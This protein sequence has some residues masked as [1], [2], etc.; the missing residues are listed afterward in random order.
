MLSSLAVTG[1]VALSRSPSLLYLVYQQSDPVRSD[2]IIRCTTHVS[3]QEQDVP[4]S[5][6][7]SAAMIIRCHEK[8]DSQSLPVPLS[9]E[10][11]STVRYQWRRECK[12]VPNCDGPR[13]AGDHQRPLSATVQPSPA[14]LTGGDRPRSSRGCEGLHSDGIECNPMRYAWLGPEQPGTDETV[15]RN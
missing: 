1:F 12:A 15:D 9:R 6:T 10:Q 5:A 8:H 14:G 7:V 4:I 2:Q 13:R 3:Y 11:Y